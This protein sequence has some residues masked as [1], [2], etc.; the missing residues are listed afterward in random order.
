[1][2]GDLRT[3]F[4]IGCGGPE[5]ATAGLPSSDFPKRSASHCWAS[6]QWHP[7]SKHVLRHNPIRRG[8]TLVE[9]LVVVSILLLLTVVVLPTIQPAS[10]SKR[11][12]EAARMI[13]VYLGAAKSQAL[14]TNRPCGVIIAREENLPQ[15]STILYQAEVPP[16]YAGNLTNAT[17]RAQEWTFLSDGSYYWLNAFF[18]VK[19][20][21]RDGDLSSGLVHRG[22]KIQLNR[23][24][25]LYTIA[26]DPSNTQPTYT[27]FPLSSSPD[28]P[29]I[30][31]APT[32]RNVDAGGWIDNYALTLILEPTSASMLAWPNVDPTDLT[33]I[34]SSTP[35][36]LTWSRPLPFEIFRRPAKS[37]ARPLRLSPGAV[38]DLDASGFDYDAATEVPDRWSFAVLDTSANPLDPDDWVLKSNVGAPIIMFSPNGAV[39]SVWCTYW[40]NSLGYYVYGPVK[41]TRPIFLLVGKQKRMPLMEDKSSVVAPDSRQTTGFIDDLTP[42]RFC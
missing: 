34:P 10:E 18:V 20:R 40:D 14:E 16:P 13:H 12:R 42:I 38:V 2:T 1:M 11:V 24:G 25:P 8:F 41:P 31:F 21:I 19:V 30:D 6:Q 22:D 3:C 29:T 15:A 5:G 36:S 32:D 26:V 33:P 9:L 28:D 23:Q 39:E 37:I 7:F 27:D 17:V 4:E 35:P